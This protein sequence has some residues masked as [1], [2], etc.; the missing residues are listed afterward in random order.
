[1]IGFTDHARDK[2]L[3][4]LGK[5]GITEKV[6]KEILKNPDELLYDA[7]TNRFIALSWSH[8]IAVIYEKTNDDLTVVTVIYS[9]QLRDTVDRRRRNGRWI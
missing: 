9:S 6:A 5:L 1:M 3:K 4:E 2:L 8:S 7:S